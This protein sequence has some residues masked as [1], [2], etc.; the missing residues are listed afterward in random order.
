VVSGNRPSCIKLSISA[1][2]SY[3]GGL[4]V[5]DLVRLVFVEGE[6]SGVMGGCDD[7]VSAELKSGSNGILELELLSPAGLVWL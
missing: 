6:V 4:C 7:E 1:S 3:G 2:A 5:D